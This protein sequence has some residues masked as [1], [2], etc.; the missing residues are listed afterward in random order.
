MRMFRKLVA[1]VVL[2]AVAA[3]AGGCYGQ[4]ALTRK[5]YAWNGEVT[6]NKFANSLIFFALIVIPVYELCSLGDWIIF[7]TVEVFTG[8]NPISRLDLP[9]GHDWV[10]RRLSDDEVEISRDGTVILLGRR[11]PGGSVTWRDVRG[12]LV[13]EVPAQVAPV[14]SR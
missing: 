7:N 4:F 3:V 6:Q 14:A 8:Q 9:G 13:A 2:V 5:I 1:A 12:D 10:A 11:A